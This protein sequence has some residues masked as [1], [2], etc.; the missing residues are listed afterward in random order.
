[1]EAQKPGG[2]AGGNAWGCTVM[3]RREETPPGAKR[4]KIW[5]EGTENWILED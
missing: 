3:N 5:K 1:M 2:R 4:K